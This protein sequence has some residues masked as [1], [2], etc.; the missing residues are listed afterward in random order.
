MGWQHRSRIARGIAGTPCFVFSEQLAHAAFETLSQLE[1]TLPLRHWLSLKTQP[2]ARLVDAALNWG[3]GVEVVS[4]FELVAALFSDV[5][6]D[7]IL[8]NGIGKHHWLARYDAPDLTVHFDSVAEV[9]ALARRAHE[10][11]WR[12]GLRC[13][14]P[15]RCDAQVGI[16]AE[17]DQFGMSPEELRVATRTLG[18]A[19]V[20]VSGVH[21]HLHTSVE[22]ADEYRR[23]LEYVRG[24]CETAGLQPRYVDIGGGLPIPG[25]RPR[26]G[27]GAASTFDRDEFGRAVRSIPSLFPRVREVWLENGR[28]VTGAAGALVVT[29]LDQ[30]ERGGRTYLI[31]DGGRTNHARLAA[32]EVHDIVLEPT[33]GGPEQETVVCGPT[34]GA[35]DSLGCWRVPGS[36]EPGDM[37]IWLNAGAYHIPLETR[38]S[39]GLA[40]VVWFDEQDQPEIVRQRETP[41][42]WW[43]QW[44]TS[45]RRMADAVSR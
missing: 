43:A 45:S 24:A 17:W 30:K 20:S 40:P 8:V 11:Q 16:D 5:P 32:T 7:R 1:S 19:G 15:Q 21:F 3:A 25:E 18:E 41:K 27:P 36:I 31:C 22:R 37:I 13:A 44:T 34:C 12:V 28:S 29:V 38:F 35:V 2:I 9:R 42:Q 14:I 33:R 39:F 26:N 10:L 4:E 23:A 6:A